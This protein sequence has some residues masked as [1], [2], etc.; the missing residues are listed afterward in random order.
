MK[1]VVTIDTFS[2]LEEEEDD[3]STN[4]LKSV[5]NEK[6]ESRSSSNTVS[7]IG[8]ITAFDCDM[9]FLPLTQYTS[10]L[11]FTI[12]SHVVHSGP[13]RACRLF[14]PIA[15]GVG[16]PEI[17][18]ILAAKQFDKQFTCFQCLKSSSVG[19][20]YDLKKFLKSV[21]LLCLGLVEVNFTT[22]SFSSSSSSSSNALSYFP[23]QYQYTRS[24][25]QEESVLFCYP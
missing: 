3:E 7:D 25:F 6:N 4:N 20:V 1:S 10:W 23:V 14:L 16:S 9:S 11:Y 21:V 12:A 17:L 13:N 19:S 5:K 22:E 2:S 15:A 18:V 8:S 24:K